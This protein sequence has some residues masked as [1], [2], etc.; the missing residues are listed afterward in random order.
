MLSYAFLETPGAGYQRASVRNGPWRY[1]QYK[2]IIFL[3]TAEGIRQVAYELD[4]RDGG[5]QQRDW[6][7]YRYDAIA[8][9]Q[10]SVAKDGHRETFDLHL[11]NGHTIPFR[12]ADPITD[13]RP[14][15][16]DAEALAEA[17]ADASGLRNVLKILEGV[18]ADG[19]GWIARETLLQCG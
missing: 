2:L 15:E 16:G 10:A 4:T 12:V 3:L 6:R 5:I 7:S 11:V 13:W 9:V 8:S 1:T 19:K 17:T 18:A 14:E